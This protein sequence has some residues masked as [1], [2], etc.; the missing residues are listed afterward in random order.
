M[1]AAFMFVITSSPFACR[2]ASTTVH[3]HS[4]RQVSATSPCGGLMLWWV[5]TGETVARDLPSAVG[6]LLEDEEFLIPFS[7]RRACRMV[8]SRS[9]GVCPCE[10]PFRSHLDNLSHIELD[11]QG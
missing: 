3:R 6:S 5:G 7:A 2:T 4:G 1:T 11:L 9:R 10:H 8:G